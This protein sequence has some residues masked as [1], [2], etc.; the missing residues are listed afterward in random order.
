MNEKELF[1]IFKEKDGL[2]L[3]EAVKNFVLNER[4]KVAK[5]QLQRRRD[6]EFLMLNIWN[7]AGWDDKKDWSRKLDIIRAEDKKIFEDRKKFKLFD[8]LQD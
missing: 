8:E 4:Q 7:N 1:K 3:Y 6:F 5:E 2:E